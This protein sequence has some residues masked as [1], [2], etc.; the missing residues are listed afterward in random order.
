MKYEDVLE[1]LRAKYGSHARAKA[2]KAPGGPGP[3]KRE[4]RVGFYIAT[5]P[6]GRTFW[7][8]HGET[9]EAA[10]A[11]DREWFARTGGKVHGV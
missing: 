5:R 7:S 4:C 9:W 2:S 3:R 8:G 11:A 1:R 6:I 10:L